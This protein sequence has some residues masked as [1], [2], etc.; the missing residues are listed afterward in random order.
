[1]AWVAA[2]DL[3]GRVFIDLGAIRHGKS[4]SFRAIVRY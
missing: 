4:M 1:M 2:R 3:V